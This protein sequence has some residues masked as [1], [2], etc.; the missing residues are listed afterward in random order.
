MMDVFQLGRKP[1]GIHSVYHWLEDPQRFL[2]LA[3][4]SSGFSAVSFYG[5]RGEFH[6][7][8]RDG[9][10]PCSV[11]FSLGF[12]RDQSELEPREHDFKT[13]T[14]AVRRLVMDDVIRPVAGDIAVHTSLNMRP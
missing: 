12:P 4:M 14:V 6:L 7:P 11:C 2:L 10:F 5:L 8:C 9:T 13:K 1:P 3:F